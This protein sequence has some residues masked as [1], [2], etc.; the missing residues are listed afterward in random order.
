MFLLLFIEQDITTVKFLKLGERGYDMKTLDAPVANGI[1]LQIIAYILVHSPFGPA[2]RR[3]LLN[4]N[5]IVNIRKL[6]SQIHLPPL[7]HPIQGLDK[8]TISK[9]QPHND[10]SVLEVGFENEKI[11]SNSL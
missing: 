10:Q 8:G 2:L 5:D 6:A 3:R 7:Y 11:R 1:L 4:D 9:V